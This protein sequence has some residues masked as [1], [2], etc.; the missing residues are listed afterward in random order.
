[1][2]IEWRSR[3]RAEPVVR[4]VSIAIIGVKDGTDSFR[5]Q[6]RCD[7]HDLTAVA[8]R[9]D[10]SMLADMHI[11]GVQPDKHERLMIEPAGPEHGDVG[12][13][14]GADP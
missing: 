4:R 10:V 5:V 1:M 7:R 8:R 14:P 6:A 13:D 12:V 11:G 9:H 3:E 2:V